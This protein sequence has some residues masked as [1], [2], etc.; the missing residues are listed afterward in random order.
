MFNFQNEKEYKS[1]IKTFVFYAEKMLAGKNRK[2]LRADDLDVYL[3]RLGETAPALI[4]LTGELNAFYGAKLPV[5]SLRKHHNKIGMAESLIPKLSEELNRNPHF[6]DIPLSFNLS[7]PQFATDLIKTQNYVNGRNDDYFDAK[8]AYWLQRT[9]YAANTALIDMNIDWQ[10]DLWKKVQEAQLDVTIAARMKNNNEPGLSTENINL[11]IYWGCLEVFDKPLQ[12][13]S[14]GLYLTMLDNCRRMQIPVTS[15]SD[16]QNALRG[17]LPEVRKILSAAQ[18]GYNRIKNIENALHETAEAVEDYEAL[19]IADIRSWQKN[20]M[21]ADEFSSSPLSAL[22][23]TQDDMNKL[24]SDYDYRRLEQEISANYKRHKKEARIFE[25][26]DS[27]R[28]QSEDVRNYFGARYKRWRQQTSRKSARCLQEL[29]AIN[30]QKSMTP[31]EILDCAKDV[32]LVGLLSREQFKLS[33]SEGGHGIVLDSSGYD[34]E[35]VEHL[36][37]N[38]ARAK[39]ADWKNMAAIFTAYAKNCQAYVSY[40]DLTEEELAAEQNITADAYLQK[41]SREKPGVEKEKFVMFS[42]RI[43]DVDL[44]YKEKMLTDFEH[45]FSRRNI[46]SLNKPR[47]NLKNYLQEGLE[48]F[49]GLDEKAPER[50]QTAI[51]DLCISEVIM[52]LY[53]QREFNQNDFNILVKEAVRQMDY[54]QSTTDFIISAAKGYQ[55]QLLKGLERQ[56]SEKG[57]TPLQK[58]LAV[59]YDKCALD[60]ADQLAYCDALEKMSEEQIA[61]SQAYS[62][63]QEYKLQTHPDNNKIT[64]LILNA[65]HTR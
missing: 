6:R 55:K 51:E 60:H 38:P 39:E 45:N 40:L 59:F 23:F 4:N 9:L 13:S 27:R 44:N 46:A 14:G 33:E 56:I 36:L 48:I 18:P 64:R 19:T 32:I 62:R 22:E 25:G 49:P 16:F 41:L 65:K 12:V 63:Y 61:W 2:I 47:E 20:E 58:N 34:I 52:P 17:S 10:E 1:V 30:L 43:F 31:E 50:L 42:E 21:A 24:L 3:E 37:R 5:L 54:P 29:A 35:Y 53:Q 11:G 15:N 26:Y 7:S 57:I 8:S 28:I